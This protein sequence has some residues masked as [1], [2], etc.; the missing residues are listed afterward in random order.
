[1]RHDTKQLCQMVEFFDSVTE[2]PVKLDLTQFV[3]TSV[4][5]VVV[6]AENFRNPHDLSKPASAR[7]EILNGRTLHVRNTSLKLPCI[8]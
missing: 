7:A 8:S 5:L 3:C 1:M 4:N 2:L 6:V